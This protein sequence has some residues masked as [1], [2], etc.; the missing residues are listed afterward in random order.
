MS[1]GTQHALQGHHGRNLDLSLSKVEIPQVL[2]KVNA[3]LSSICCGYFINP[4]TVVTKVKNF[5]DQIGITFDE[6]M[7]FGDEGG[8]SLTAKQYVSDEMSSDN[9]PGGLSIRFNWCKIKGLYSFEIELQRRM[10]SSLPIITEPIQ[11]KW[12]FAGKLRKERSK[13]R[14]SRIGK[15]FKRKYT[16]RRYGVS[17]LKGFSHK[18]FKKA[19]FN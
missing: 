16:K 12:T 7:F 3:Y 15:S 14:K 13:I 1:F 11:E 6:P 5:L 17:T 4:Y 9:I 8:I 2:D 18:K 19:K 10:E